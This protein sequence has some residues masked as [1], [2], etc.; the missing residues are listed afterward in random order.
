MKIL[1]RIHSDLEN[2][3]ATALKRVLKTPQGFDFSSNDY[4]SLSK[5]PRIIGAVK[6]GLERYGYGS[7][8]SRFI[9]GERD[10]HHELEKKLA[11]YK[12]SDRALLFNS[13]YAANIGA[14]TSLVK[15]GDV[16]F[17][18]QLNHASL[19]DG[20]RLSGATV[21]VFPHLDLRFLRL[22]LKKIPSSVQAFI[23]TES[24]FSMDGDVAPLDSYAELSRQ[25]DAG[26]IID[27][28]HALGIFGYCGAGLIDHFKVSDQVLCSTNGLGKVMATMGAFVAG[29]DVVIEAVLQRA[30]TLIYTTAMP[31][32]SLCAIEASLAIVEQGD[33]L[34]SELKARVEYFWHLLMAENLLSRRGLPTAI[35][36]IIIG[37]NLCALNIA[38]KMAEAGFD[39]RAIRPPTVPEGSARLRITTNVAH[40]FELIE[41]CV[42]HLRKFL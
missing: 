24:L 32:S 1:A 35:F 25:F 2:L 18:D 14:I 42:K 28:A 12:G 17:S 33:N 29:R 31:P 38:E 13:G 21:V 22:E 19:I 30:R 7:T 4:F 20:L 8:S 3:G 39:I 40:S 11:I 27:E 41:D 15:K 6:T 16:V 34:R 9:R 37:D 5:D 23:V 26:L 10:L 36:P